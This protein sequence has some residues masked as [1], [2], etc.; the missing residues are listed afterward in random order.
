MRELTLVSSG[1]NGSFITFSV[2][3]QFAA[4][5][6]WVSPE[7]PI[8]EQKLEETGLLCQER[9]VKI[10]ALVKEEAHEEQSAGEDQ[11]EP[12]LLHIKEEQDD[13]WTSLEREQL[14]LKETD[15][16]RFLFNAGSIKSEDDEEKTLVSQLHQQQTEDRDVP[17]S[18]SADHVTAEMTSHLATRS[19]GCCVSVKI[20][21]LV[22]EEA[23]EEQSAGED[24]QEPEHLHIK[25][26]QDDLW[27]SLEREQ[28]HLKETD[29]ARFLFTAGSIKS[30]DDEEK[31]LVS[32]LHQQQT[33]DRDVPASSS[34]DHV[35]AEMTS[36]LATR[37]SGCCVS[38]ECVIVKQH[39]DSCREVQK[40]TKTF[41]CD[42][43]GKEFMG[44]SSLN[45][46]MRIHTGQKP[47]A[48]ELCGQRF[49]YKTSLNSHMSAHTGQKPFVCELCGQRFSH[50]TS[51]NSHMSVHTGQKPFACELCG[52]GFNRK[53]DLNR[54]TRVHTGQKPFA[55]ELCGQRFRYKTSLNSHMSAHTGQKP[56]A[57][58]LCGKGFNRKKDLNRHTRVHT[59]HK[60]FICELCGQRFS[61]KTS[62]NSHMSVHTG[63][64]P[65]ACGLCGKGF[66]RKTD[67]NRH[68]RVHT[69]QKPFACELCG[70]RFR[71]KTS[72]K[73]HMSAHTGQKPLACEL[74]GKGFNRKRDLNNHTSVHP[75]QKPFGCV[76]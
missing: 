59:G 63:Q 65:F 37:S 40:K 5:H 23:H 6:G 3:S 72:L 7:M 9:C 53:T 10:M 1:G 74:C 25:E 43:C 50:K 73:C 49:R 36:H 44:K 24:Q 4:E 13:L 33:E 46:H 34:A 54:H 58:E 39:A 16:A 26:E 62:L 60:P 45:S 14:H 61:H 67:L 56:F 76:T 41:S 47:F 32:Q 21:A 48:C 68:T 2:P 69:A 8:S 51:L 75:G 18:S 70:Q 20:M 29:A 52:K 71:Y 35:T 30:E 12:E 31:P 57:C 66:T 19:S 64:K 28:L 15:A 22:K 11:Q 38:K 42:H 27:T 17:A 55:C